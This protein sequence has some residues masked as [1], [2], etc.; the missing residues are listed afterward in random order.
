MQNLLLCSKDVQNPCVYAYSQPMSIFCHPQDRHSS[1]KQPISHI[2][3]PLRRS[4]FTTA[5]HPVCSKTFRDHR[6]VGRT[7]FLRILKEDYVTSV[8]WEPMETSC[9]YYYHLSCANH[10]LFIFFDVFLFQKM[11]LYSFY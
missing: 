9:C 4:S 6:S 3:R 10:A 7:S 1:N 11:S 8:F 2:F 5:T